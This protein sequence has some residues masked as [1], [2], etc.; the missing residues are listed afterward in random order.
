M[1]IDEPKTPYGA[2]DS[3]NEEAKDELD[4]NLLAARIAAEG[5]KGPRTRRASEPSG[6]EEDLKLLSPEVGYSFKGANWISSNSSIIQY[7]DSNIG[8]FSIAP[9]LVI[10]LPTLR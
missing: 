2:Y 1:K 6:D 5:H 4:A 7:C 9:P 8:L 3:D 10:A